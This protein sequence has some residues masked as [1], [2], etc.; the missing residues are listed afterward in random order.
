MGS[1]QLTG[2]LQPPVRPD[3]THSQQPVSD[4]TPEGGQGSKTNRQSPYTN[5]NLWGT[6][7]RRT[8]LWAGDNSLA[9]SKVPERSR[10]ASVASQ[11]L[12]RN[13]TKDWTMQRSGDPRPV[14]TVH[15]P[16]VTVP[17]SG[18][19]WR[20]SCTSACCACSEEA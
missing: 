9:H 6:E 1:Q 19:A 14:L 4:W 15:K 12:P 16:V 17:R 3:V 20:D 7:Q 18:P 13:E 5:T 10:E 8:V 11:R 2:E